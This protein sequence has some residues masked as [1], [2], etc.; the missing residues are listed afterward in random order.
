MTNSEAEKWALDETRRLTLEILRGQPVRVWL[1][2]SRAT[3]QARPFSDIDLALQA[4]PGPMDR[5]L[6]ARL[7][8]ALEESCIP[9]K[10]DIVN[11]N[12]ADP[13]VR[14]RIEREGQLWTD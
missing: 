1:F 4:D 10:V 13:A 6:L 2:G 8:E 7:S 11:M 5:A 9:F 14:A 12:T 3:G